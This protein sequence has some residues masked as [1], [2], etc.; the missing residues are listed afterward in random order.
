M[1]RFILFLFLT[2]TIHLHAQY[3]SDNKKYTTVYPQDLCKTLQANPGFILLDVRS[4]GE[5]DDTLSS[6]QSLNIGHIENSKHID[7]RQLP[8]RWKELLV[9]REK[10]VFIYCSH[11][12]RSR[13]ASRLLSDSGFTRIFNVNEGLTGFYIDGISNENCK[14][15]KIVS[16]LPYKIISPRQLVHDMLQHELYT[17]LDIR[18]DSAYNSRAASAVLNIQGRFRDALHLPFSEFPEKASSISTKKNI[19]LIDSYGDE[20]PKAAKYLL[21]HGYKNVSILFNG[22]D[23][24]VDYMASAT[25]KPPVE[26]MPGVNYQII[27]P[28]TFY[29]MLQR[30]KTL[31]I[32]DVRDKDEFNNQSKTAWRNIGNII[33]SINIPATEIETSMGSLAIKDSSIVIVGSVNNDYVYAAANTLQ[34]SGYKNIYVLRGG[35]WNLRWL[36]HNQ[37]GREMLNELVINVPEENQ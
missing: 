34:Q 2:A 18:E 8:D 32:I 37:K 5:Y 7:I 9:Y 3:K 29:D 10:P 36:A 23:E 15:Y 26:W 11:S 33:N 22:M 28:A 14:N 13:R 20:S 4:Q 17:F 12:Q 35:I 25:E 1:A 21:E 6:S 31:T 19:L 24:W 30:K 27:S 16:N